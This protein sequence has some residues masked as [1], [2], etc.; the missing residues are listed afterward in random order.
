MRIE[1]TG[2]AEDPLGAG[3]D[4]DDDEQDDEDHHDDHAHDGTG[5]ERF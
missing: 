1:L 5:A 4:G 2:E 3:D